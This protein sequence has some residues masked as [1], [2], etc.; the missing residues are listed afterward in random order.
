MNLDVGYCTTF[1]DDA[2]FGALYGA[3]NYSSACSCVAKPEFER[4]DMRKEKLARPCLRDIILKHIS[5][6]LDIFSMG[7]LATWRTHSILHHPNLSTLAH[8]PANQFKSIPTQEH[9]ENDLNLST[10]RPAYWLMN[11]IIVAKEEG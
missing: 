6:C 8:F 5:T 1:Q 7:R 11:L 10:L 9:L 4:G 2:I 3:F